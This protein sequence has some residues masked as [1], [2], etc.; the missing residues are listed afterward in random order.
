MPRYSSHSESYFS[1]AFGKLDALAEALRVIV[2]DNQVDTLVGSGL[3]GTLVVPSLA[4][5]CDVPFW[6]IV[7]KE[8]TTHTSRLVEGAIG[9][10]WLFVDDFISSGD[11]LRRT[12]NEVNYV[13]DGSVLVGT[14]VYELGA[15][16]QFTPAASL[17]Y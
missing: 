12:R 17:Y 7:R 6:A 1:R 15:G 10:R 13:A 8:K 9:D 4:R 14:F 11:T 16:G 3:S 5:A 2:T